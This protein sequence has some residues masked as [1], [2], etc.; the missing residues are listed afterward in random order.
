MRHPYFSLKLEEP[1]WDVKRA[2]WK[3]GLRLLTAYEPRTGT[4]PLST[5]RTPKTE[6]Y[7]GYLALRG[8]RTPR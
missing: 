6:V 3:Q 2:R 7:L 1:V 5:S 8:G 4:P